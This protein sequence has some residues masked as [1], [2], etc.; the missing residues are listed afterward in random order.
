MAGL[1]W[2]SLPLGAPVT[3]N[4]QRARIG[5][6]GP[7]LVGSDEMAQTNQ[8]ST[9]D[10]AALKAM[11]AEAE[12]ARLLANRANEFMHVAGSGPG[13]VGT[14]PGYADVP[15]ISNLIPNVA[16]MAHNAMD[17]Q[18]KVAQLDAINQATW[19]QMRSQGSGAIRAYEA[20]D[21]KTAF[22][23]TANWG[24]A[25]GSITERLNQ[26]AQ[27]NEQRLAFIDQQMRSG[28]G[29]A[30]AQLAWQ[31]QQQ[32]GALQARSAQARAPQPPQ[33]RPAPGAPQAP[34]GPAQMSD[35]DL[36]RSLGLQ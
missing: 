17:P 3:I 31:R 25:N 12:Q 24:P 13:A 35:D 26:E 34:S 15:L 30:D 9:S 19:A 33:G 23:N 2:K 20:N 36:R 4:G 5:P 29:L 27:Q 7:V 22:P 16:K 18:T 14:G 32:N 10:Q 21:W 1:W 6:H 11:Q 28:G 8:R